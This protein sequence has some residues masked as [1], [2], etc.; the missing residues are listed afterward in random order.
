MAYVIPYEALG[1]RTSSSPSSSSLLGR[2]AIHPATRHN[3]ATTTIEKM[4]PNC[5]ASER[6]LHP[7]Q[8]GMMLATGAVGPDGWSTSLRATRIPEIGAICAAMS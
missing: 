2:R 6:Q 4:M 8:G 7:E 5:S 3:K 1:M